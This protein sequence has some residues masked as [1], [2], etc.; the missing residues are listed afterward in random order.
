MKNKLQA[1]DDST[2]LGQP[3]LL[4]QPQ[5][6]QCDHSIRLAVLDECGRWKSFSND[7]ELTDFVSVCVG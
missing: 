5:W 1:F 2:P 6:V 7:R 4:R 3:P